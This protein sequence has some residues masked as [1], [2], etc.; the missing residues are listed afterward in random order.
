MRIAASLGMRPRIYGLLLLTLVA[1]ARRIDS[2]TNSGVP[3]SQAPYHLSVA[4]DEVVL[5]F[6]A[7][8]AHG[9]PINVSNSMSYISLTTANS[10][11]EFSPSS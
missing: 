6:H 5:T 4:V 11:E 2:Q 1:P 3:Q 9:L 10:P 7:A 8:D